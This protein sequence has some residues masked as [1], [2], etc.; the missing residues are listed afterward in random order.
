MFDLPGKE[1]KEGEG[2]I[3]GSIGVSISRSVNSASSTQPVQGI[4]QPRTHETDETKHHN[5]RDW[6]IVYG[7]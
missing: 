7:S 3:M 1:S 4:V 5:L 6:M 2:C